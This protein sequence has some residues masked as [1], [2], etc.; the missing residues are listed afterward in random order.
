MPPFQPALISRLK[1]S[2]VSPAV[3]SE[4]RPPDS[5]DTPQRL[6]LPQST[7]PASLSSSSD[8]PVP[9][10]KSPS[11]SAFAHA[12]GLDS[13]GVTSTASPSSAEV[14]GEPARSYASSAQ[15]SI[16][17][18]D[19]RSTA[20]DFLR[21]VS[22]KTTQADDLAT[23]RRGMKGRNARRRREAP[24]FPSLAID[25]QDQL[26]HGTDVEDFGQQ[27]EAQP[28][29]PESSMYTNIPRILR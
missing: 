2:H 1:Q 21:S 23:V 17:T 8:R 10:N 13:I 9:G 4:S 5:E 26:S 6:S 20:L 18:P 11:T 22:K 19:S 28:E 3:A 16:D 29:E 15:A 7:R 14:S 25:Q 12:S 27:V 24:L